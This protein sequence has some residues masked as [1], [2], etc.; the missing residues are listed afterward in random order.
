[1]QFE[2]VFIIIHNTHTTSLEYNHTQYDDEQNMVIRASL[3][4]L[5]VK[6]NSNVKK[7]DNIFTIA[8]DTDLP[9]PHIASVNSDRVVIN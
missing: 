4:G 9:A 7:D 1:M 6:V 2:C 8:Y 5:E 3:Y